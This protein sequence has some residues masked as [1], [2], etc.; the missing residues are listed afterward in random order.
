MKTG[1]AA[2]PG[3]TPIELI[4]SGGQKLL[5]M[6]TTLLNNTTN[7][8]K[9]PEEWKVAIIISMQSITFTCYKVLVVTNTYHMRE[10][11]ENLRFVHKMYVLHMT[12]KVNINYL[13]KRS[14][15]TRLYN[16]KIV[17]HC[18]VRTGTFTN[19]WTNNADDTK[20]KSTPN[21]EIPRGQ[22]FEKMSSRFRF[23]DE[24]LATWHEVH[25]PTQVLLPSVR[26][27]ATGSCVPC[28]EADM[29][30]H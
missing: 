17:F 29:I 25:A 4:K 14:R 8:E 30:L 16:D 18:A 15:M 22:R 21:I 10:H 13:P 24:T 20:K 5:E 27:Q 28:D 2:D 12:L 9:V 23:P 19:F 26:L 7:G 11:W 3:D 6:I 1:R